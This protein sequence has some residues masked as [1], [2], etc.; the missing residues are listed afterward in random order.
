MPSRNF[1]HGVATIAF[2]VAVL[3]MASLAIQAILLLL[4]AA[5]LATGLHGT[6]AR[7]E[8]ILPGGRRISLFVTILA[9][10]AVLGLLGALVWPKVAGSIASVR[11]TA[12]ELG[13]RI[14]RSE[15][16]VNLVGDVNGADKEGQLQ[17]GEIMALLDRATN[18]ITDSFKVLS[19]LLLVGALTLFLAWNPAL[20]RKGVLSLLPR[21]LRPRGNE[22]LDSVR[23]ALWHWMLGQGIAMIVIG[24]LT[25]LGLY[26][27]GMEYA[28]LLGLIAALL[29]FIPYVGP[30]LSAIPGILLGF[31]ESPHMALV[32]GGVYLGVQL[33]ESNFITPYILRAEASLPPVLTL[34]ATVA[35]GLIFGPLGLIIATP[36]SLIA[37]VLYREL[38]PE[39]VLGE[40]R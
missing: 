3:W 2:V 39:V 32:A 19:S 1:I 8:R 7:L 22:V 9:I 4:A 12:A 25:T 24:V 34:F 28:L 37:L 30:F 13:G 27:V 21:R 35:M 20:Y 36:L 15:F 14:A 26:L 10:T 16:F 5:I 29:Q 31:A 18:I 11:E 23:L 38:Y 33:V 6:A 40:G 17:S